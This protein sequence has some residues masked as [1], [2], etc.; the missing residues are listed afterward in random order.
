M[1]LMMGRKAM[2]M[3][4]RSLERKKMHARACVTGREAIIM[5]RRLRVRVVG[6]MMGEGSRDICILT[7]VYL[8]SGW[9]G[10]A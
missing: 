10:S 7:G 4:W 5:A 2:R 8:S 6:Y 9:T 3:A 1:I